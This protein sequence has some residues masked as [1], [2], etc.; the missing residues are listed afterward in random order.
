M[1]STC[2]KQIETKLYVIPLP[3]VLSDAKHGKHTHFELV[4]ATVTLDD[5]REGT[6]YTYTGGKGGHAI[7]AMIKH[8]LAPALIEKDAENID[9]IYDFMEWHVHYVGRGGVAAFAVSAIDIALWDI[10]C[11]SQD[12]P[13]WQ[14]AG[15]A[16]NVTK[17]YCGGIDLGFSTEKLLANI[18]GYLDRGFNG[19][20]IKVGRDHLDD[21]VAR[22]RAVRELIGPEITFMVDANYSMTVDQAIHAANAFKEYDIFWFEEPTLPDDYP[23]YARIADATG[24]PLA[25]GENLRTIREFGY[26]FDQAKLSYIQPD[27]S[28][29]GGITGWLRVAALARQYGVTV[30]THGMQE[31][32]VSLLSAQPNAGWLEVH[33]FPIN[34][35]TTRPLVVENFHAVAPDMPGTGVIFDWDKLTEYAAEASITSHA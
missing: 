10:R 19:V 31:L 26:A 27:A 6:G 23:G 20:K 33:S 21:D 25:M 17:A 11:K 34:E 14:V 3:E 18:H 2:I 22:V 28:N 15:G 9:A 32:H 4:T 8:D 16:S 29:C 1:K 13:L 7:Y 12:R 35:Y 24:V 30:C 5:G